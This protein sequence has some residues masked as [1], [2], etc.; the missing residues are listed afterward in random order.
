MSFLLMLLNAFLKVR[1]VYF[2]V[3]STISGAFQ[4]S[5]YSIGAP[6]TCASSTV[7]FVGVEGPFH[8]EMGKSRV[9][10]RICCLLGCVRAFSQLLNGFSKL[11]AWLIVL[12]EWGLV[13]FLIWDS[14][15]CWLSAASFEKN[16]IHLLHL[17]LVLS[18]KHSIDCS[19]C[20]VS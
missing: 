12:L 8:D 13:S 20:R 4:H 15:W 19:I 1:A 11:L 9:V 2:K 6:P 16:A 3:G 17:C 18:I 14:Q 10:W 7:N 5:E